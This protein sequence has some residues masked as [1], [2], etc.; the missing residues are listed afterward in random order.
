MA[1]HE[2]PVAM[3]IKNKLNNWSN[4]QQK[5]LQNCNLFHLDVIYLCA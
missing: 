1:Q 2:M 3:F 4:K 5:R